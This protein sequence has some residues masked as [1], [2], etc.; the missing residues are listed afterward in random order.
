MTIATI[1]ALILIIWYS[2]E[3]GKTSAKHG[4]DYTIGPAKMIFST[5]LSVLCLY[6]AGFFVVWSWPQFAWFVL[7][8]TGVVVFF[9]SP[10]LEVKGKNDMGMSAIAYALV[11]Y[12]YYKGGVFNCFFNQ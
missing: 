10:N 1:A 11:W 4:E 5:I 7:V 6:F 12:I 8:S 2:Y 9:S 3:F